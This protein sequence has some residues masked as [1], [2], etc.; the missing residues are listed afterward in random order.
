M[1]EDL[2]GVGCAL[3]AG[4]GWQSPQPCSST[5]FWN[6][7]LVKKPSLPFLSSSTRCRFLCCID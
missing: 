2:T 5:D 1:A 6:S 4:W 7:A 3:L